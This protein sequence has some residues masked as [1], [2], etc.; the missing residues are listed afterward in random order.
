MVKCYYYYHNTHPHPH[1]RHHNYIIT[2]VID[3]GTISMIE[4]V[5]GIVAIMI[6]LN[7]DI[8]I[9]PFS[10]KFNVIVSYDMFLL[11]YISETL[12][13]LLFTFYNTSS[14]EGVVH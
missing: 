12:P 2:V 9:K 6:M 10:V 5:A 3:I 8:I 13:L 4:I 11:S 14:L 7:Y 1:R